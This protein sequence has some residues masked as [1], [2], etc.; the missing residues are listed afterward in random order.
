GQCVR[1]LTTDTPECVCAPGY[2]KLWSQR[3]VSLAPCHDDQCRDRDC[4]LGTCQLEYEDDGTGRRALGTTCLCPSHTD[5]GDR[6]Y[7]DPVNARCVR[8]PCLG[9][10]PGHQPGPCAATDFCR[11]NEPDE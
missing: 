2:S 4:G 11:V 5:T 1:N 3:D 6:V 9:P 10:D 8:D 7:W